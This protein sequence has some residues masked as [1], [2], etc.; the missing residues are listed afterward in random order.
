MFWHHFEN[1]NR[2]SIICWSKWTAHWS[3]IQMRMFE[4]SQIT[5]WAQWLKT[6]K[7]AFQRFVNLNIFPLS[8]I[9]NTRWFMLGNKWGIDLNSQICS[10][11]HFC[12]WIY[13][14]INRVKH[15]F[16]MLRMHV[17]NSWSFHCDQQRILR[18]LLNFFE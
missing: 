13:P 2:C 1:I 3:V 7:R 4:N 14:S 9:I 10:N 15:G 8:P 6:L 16:Y 11:T 18:C 5:N 17:S 12:F